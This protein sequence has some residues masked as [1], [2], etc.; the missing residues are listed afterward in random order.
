[1]GR[2]Y[3]EPSFFSACVSQRTSPKSLAW[4][5]VLTWNVQHLANPNKR[6]HFVT[7]CLRLGLI[8]PQILTPDLLIEVDE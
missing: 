2:V 6:T 4:R 8:P 5:D 1:M 3:L 7:L